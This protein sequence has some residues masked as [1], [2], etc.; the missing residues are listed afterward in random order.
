MA[1]TLID[2][3]E[4]KVDAA[5]GQALNDKYRNNL[6]ELMTNLC[7]IN[8]GGAYYDQ[9]IPGYVFILNGSRT[10]PAGI[11]T[12]PIYISAVQIPAGIAGVRVDVFCSCTITDGLHGIQVVIGAATAT[13]FNIPGASAWVTLNLTGVPSGPNQTINVNCVKNAA[14]TVVSFTTNAVRVTCTP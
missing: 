3:L 8:I 6:D 9:T 11:V 10:F 7:L 4:T 1:W 13:V 2:S 5:D 14:A 12:S